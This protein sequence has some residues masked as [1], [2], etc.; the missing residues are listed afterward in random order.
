MSRT[1]LFL[2]LVGVLITAAIFLGF[3]GKEGSGEGKPLGSKPEILR[4]EFP[5]EIPADGRKVV[6]TIYF[7]DPDADIV[8]VRFEVVE[9]LIFDPFAFDPKVHGQ[10]EGSFQFYVFTYFPQ[11]VTLQVILV[12]AQDHTSDP[13]ELTFK[14]IFPSQQEGS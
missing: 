14:A 4:V 11:E 8:K 2:I 12:D 1:L 9:A 3:R 5:R 7:R 10:K 13:V 6:G